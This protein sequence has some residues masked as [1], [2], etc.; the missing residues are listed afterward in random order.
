MPYQERIPKRYLADSI[1][2]QSAATCFN[3]LRDLALLKQ[4]ETPAEWYCR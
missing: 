1:H 3:D 2:Q 4:L